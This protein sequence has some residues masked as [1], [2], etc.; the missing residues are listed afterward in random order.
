MYRALIQIFSSQIKIIQILFK[1]KNELILENLALRQQLASYKA[2]NHKP[3]LTNIDR[4]F[5]VTLK[6]TW[7]R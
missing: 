7:L 4:F 2:Q 5:W 6:Q 3:R 1:S